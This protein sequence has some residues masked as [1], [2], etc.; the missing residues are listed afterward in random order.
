MFTCRDCGAEL[1]FMHVNLPKRQINKWVCP[2]QED[3][4]HPQKFECAVCGTGL[5]G[6][7]TGTPGNW[8]T[9]AE[10]C[11]NEQCPAKAE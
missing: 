9:Y 8:D 2:M 6:Q 1:Q 3:E 7:G 5:I 11:P 4:G 10:Y